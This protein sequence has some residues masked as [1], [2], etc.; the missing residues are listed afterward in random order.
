MKYV[1]LNGREYKINPSNYLDKPP[2]KSKLHL[3]VREFLQSYFKM[4]TILE[5]VGISGFPKG[6][7][8]YLDFFLPNLSL[9]FEG[10]GLQHTEHVY[11]FHPTKSD[12]LLAKHNDRLK[13]EWATLNNFTLYEFYYNETEEDWR[14][15]IC[16]NK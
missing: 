15:K 8:L 12:F 9:I 5:E 7:T 13:R 10:N 4:Q 1:G 6:K 16:G 2:N 14:K 3:Q 11:H